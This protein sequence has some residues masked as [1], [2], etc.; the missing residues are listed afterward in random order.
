MTKLSGHSKAVDRAPGKPTEQPF[1]MMLMHDG[2]RARAEAQRTISRLLAGSLTGFDVHL[3]EISFSEIAHPEISAEAVELAER[4][5]LFILATVNESNLPNEIV[6]WL[7]RWFQSRQQKEAA[8]VCLVGSSHGAVLGSP[9]HLYLQ[10]LAG[11]HHLSFF[12]SAFRM[13]G[14][15]L[16]RG[17]ERCGISSGMQQVIDR[18]YPRPE[19]WGIN[20]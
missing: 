10:H 12:S 6:A 13:T 17:V 11:E 3:D 20:E 4:C 1:Q 2:K 5:D 18:C 16:R 8:V 9:V 15:D 7:H 19:A 14:D